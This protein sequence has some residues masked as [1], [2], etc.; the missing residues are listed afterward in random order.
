MAL[1][2]G[3]NKVSPHDLLLLSLDCFRSDARKT[4]DF[5]LWRRQPKQSS[6][7]KSYKKSSEMKNES[8]QSNLAISFYFSQLIFTFET[9]VEG[10]NFFFVAIIAFNRWPIVDFWNIVISSSFRRWQV[11]CAKVFQ[12]KIKITWKITKLMHFLDAFAFIV[13][14]NAKFEKIYVA[15]LWPIRNC[16]N[17]Q[18][19]GES[20]DFFSEIVK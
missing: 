13:C 19:N 1:G 14:N 15:V 4:P 8:N 6:T 3:D 2:D 12:R 17:G 10:K 11:L 5:E 16:R 7:K 18:R 9:S 20:D